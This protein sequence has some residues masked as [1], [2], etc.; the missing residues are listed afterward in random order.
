MSVPVSLAL[1]DARG[2]LVRTAFRGQSHAAGRHEWAWDLRDQAGARVSA[3]IYFYQFEA[4][5]FAQTKKL[6][7]YD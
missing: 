3:G 2:R 6:V 5:T 1:Y 7:V 4:G